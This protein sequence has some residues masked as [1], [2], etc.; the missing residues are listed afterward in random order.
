MVGLRYELNSERLILGNH[1][2]DPRQFQLHLHLGDVGLACKRKEGLV[3]DVPSV[4]D[5]SDALEHE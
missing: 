3:G 5:E 2:L 4:A 1:V